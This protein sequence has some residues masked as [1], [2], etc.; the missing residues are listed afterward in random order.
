MDI[1]GVGVF[2]FVLVTSAIFLRRSESYL[3]LVLKIAQ[4]ENMESYGA[5]LPQW[6]LANVRSGVK[7][8][9]KGGHLDTEIV[10][11]YSQ[12]L[13]EKSKEFYVTLRI[14]TAFDKRS[15]IYSYDGL[16]VLVGSYQSF[17]IGGILIKG[18][19][20]SLNNDNYP[21]TTKKYLV[22]G[23]LNPNNIANQE[24]YWANTISNG[25]SNYLAEL[26]KLG[27]TVK[28]SDGKVIADIKEVKLLPATR[29][30]VSGDR[31]V[32]VPDNDRKQVKLKLEVTAIDLNGVSLYMGIM[33]IKINNQLNLDFGKFNVNLTVTD[34]KEI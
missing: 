33:P 7:Q 5:E 14:R 16:P 3:T 8:F 10:K 15:G 21:V 27:N 34:F 11:V 13:S 32:E 18:V 22:E 12:N 20:V 31:L 28:D 19:V 26:F 1:L 9:D 25:V 4:F 30:F 6:Y 29:K 23:F 17:K 24:P 2:I